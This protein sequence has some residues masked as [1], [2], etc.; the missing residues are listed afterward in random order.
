MIILAIYATI[1]AIATTIYLIKSRQLQTEDLKFVFQKVKFWST[2][3]SPKN[4]NELRYLHVK[5]NSTNNLDKSLTR[6]LRD[7]EFINRFESYLQTSDSMDVSLEFLQEFET[8]KRQIQ[9]T[10]LKSAN[11]LK[12]ASNM[13]A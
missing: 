11:A 3:K 12:P 9:L 13:V 6:S 7:L 2:K 8:H 4:N 10:A 5:G 1:L